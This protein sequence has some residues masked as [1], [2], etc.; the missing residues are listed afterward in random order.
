MD[1]E[2]ILWF[3]VLYEHIVD[4]IYLEVIGKEC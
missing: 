3:L 4:L 1:F 2:L